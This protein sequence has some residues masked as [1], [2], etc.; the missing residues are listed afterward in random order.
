M[1]SQAYNEIKTSG[2]LPSPTG[3]ALRILELADNP[4]I[5][6]E[7]IAEVVESDPALSGRLLKVV[8]SPLAGMSRQVASVMR[9]VALLGL[10]TVT[11][12]SLSFSL[13]KNYRI[14]KCAAFDYDNFWADSLARATS[15]RHLAQRLRTFAP[16]E[17]FTCGLLSKVG[18]LALATVFPD[19]YEAVLRVVHQGDPSELAELETSM[20]QVNHNELTCMMMADWHIPEVFSQAVLNQDDPETLKKT[21][22]NRSQSMSQILHFSGVVSAILTQDSVHRDALSEL[23]IKANRLGIPPDVYHEVF[24]AISGEWREAAEVYQV[25]TR[26]VPPLAEIYAQAQRTRETVGALDDEVA[27]ITAR[28]ER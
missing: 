5:K 17:A 24:D 14:G 12:L 15:T 11:T 20:F 23:T 9:A 1:A 3:V 7:S 18:R 19:R 22:E 21:P 16:D 25:K 2:N 10:R 6:L 28:S 27:A 13:V 26:R 4:D 8:N